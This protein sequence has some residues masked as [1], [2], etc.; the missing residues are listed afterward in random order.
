MSNK[1]LKELEGGTKQAVMRKKIITH[2]IYNG[3]STITELAKEL[4]LSVPTV[5]KF[6]D[7]MCTEGYLN[8]YGKLETAG[9]R[10]PSLYGLN[11]D[12]GYFMGVELCATEVNIGVINFKG[13]MVHVKRHI[14]FV[15][16]NTLQ[17]LD[18]FCGIIKEFMDEVTLDK[19][20]LLNINVNLIGRVNSDL[21]YSYSVFNLS[22]RPLTEILS[23]KLGGFR[24]SIDNDTRAMAY[25]EFMQGI[26]R[27]EKNVLFINVSWGLAA[28]IIIDGKMYKG[29]SGF[30][31]E[32]GH[33]YGYDNEILCHC[34]KKGC[35]ETEASGLALHRILLEQL[36]KGKSSIIQQMKED[37]SQITLDDIIEAVEREDML[38]IELVEELGMKL[39]THIAGLV[40]IFNPE[41]VV[42]GGLLSQTGDYLIQPI[43]STL[44]K[45]TLNLMIYDSFI[46]QSKLKDKAGIVGACMVARSRLFE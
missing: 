29:R 8:D 12:S 14:P 21:G 24:V 11:P 40:N 18:E 42:I 30:S 17:S 39:G 9:G 34:G 31:G 23:E 46:V 16:S 27:N 6:I 2:Y 22:E 15:S 44:R 37:V 19:E 33:N 32:F 10:H 26:V 28:G 43:A 4:D 45:Y 25:G 35:I 36:A 1:L 13:D 7:E 3:T 20:K 41:M 5:T 38:C